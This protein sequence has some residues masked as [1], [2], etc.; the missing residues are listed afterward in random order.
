MGNI[1]QGSGWEANI[2]WD[3]AECYISLKT[4]PEC[5]VS[6]CAQVWVVLQLIYWLG[7]FTSNHNEADHH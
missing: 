6:C 2:A 5:Y 7:S 3:K 4:T 1:A